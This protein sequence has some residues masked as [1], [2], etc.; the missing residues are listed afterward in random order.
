MKTRRPFLSLFALFL[1]IRRFGLVPLL[2][3][4]GL[5]TGVLYFISIFN[6][7]LW[8]GLQPQEHTRQDFFGVQIAVGCGVY[9][10]LLVLLTPVL[11]EFVSGMPVGQ[12]IEFFFTR[13]VNRRVFLRAER[14]AQFVI[15]IGPLL[16]NL[17]LSPYV[18]ELDFGSGGI[19]L[20]HEP[21][22]FAAWLTWA[23]ILCIYLVSGYHLLAV[24]RIQKLAIQYNTATQGH[25]LVVLAVYAPLLFITGVI[26]IFATMRINIYEQFFW[27]FARHLWLSWAGLA[28]LVCVVQPLSERNLQ[29]L[30]FV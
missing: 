28:A 11:I 27:L 8:L 15:L 10:F 21:V 5:A 17:A 30:E 16:L 18:R 14:L 26:A 12:L 9:M 13:A 22:L 6:S 19:H 25:W 24:T 1:G 7:A 23:G 4:L 20:P 29:K 3:W 2:L